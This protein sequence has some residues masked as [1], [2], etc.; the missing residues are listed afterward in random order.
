VFVSSCVRCMPLWRTPDTTRPSSR[1]SGP[2]SR[3]HTTCVVPSCAQE[4]TFNFVLRLYCHRL[5][6][7]TRLYL[8]A[9][10]THLYDVILRVA[11]I[12]TPRE[13]ELD[14]VIALYV[15]ETVAVLLTVH[16]Q[17]SVR[18][19]PRVLQWWRSVRMA[20]LYLP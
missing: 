3:A 19:C 20:V 10:Q 7:S 6:R 13:G 17:A 9:H 12:E 1:N 11:S 15:A 16:D 18:V 8:T 14:D 2:L 5:H 4:A